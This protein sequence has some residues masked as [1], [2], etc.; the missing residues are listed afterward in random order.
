MYNISEKLWCKLAVMDSSIHSAHWMTEFSGTSD[1]VWKGLKWI[2]V[3]KQRIFHAN[4]F[5]KSLNRVIFTPTVKDTHVISIIFCLELC[6]FPTKIDY[7][8]CNA[9]KCNS[10]FLW[11]KNTLFDS[12]LSEILKKDEDSILEYL[13]EK[14]QAKETPIAINCYLYIF[15]KTYRD[16]H[17]HSVQCWKITR[18][19]TT[20]TRGKNFKNRK[21]KHFWEKIFLHINICWINVTSEKSALNSPAMKKFKKSKIGHEDQ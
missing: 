13:S 4:N 3:V 16:I 19:A 21:K 15:L 11:N 8:N 14:I 18:L 7:R 5:C 17:Q 10:F 20:R 9:I 2:K 1:A 6:S 12:E